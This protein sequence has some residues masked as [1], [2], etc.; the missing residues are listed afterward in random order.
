MAKNAVSVELLR[1]NLGTMA[2][3][4]DTLRPARAA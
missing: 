3:F 2:D 4:L 1:S